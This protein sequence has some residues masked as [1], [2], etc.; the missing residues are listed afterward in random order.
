MA[1]LCCSIVTAI[2]YIHVAFIL[3]LHEQYIRYAPRILPHQTH[4]FQ[5]KKDIF[6]HM[7]NRM[8]SCEKFYR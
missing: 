2:G 5:F 3:I 6:I 8:K 1:I 4:S 7:R